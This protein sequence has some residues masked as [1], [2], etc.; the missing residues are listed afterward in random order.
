MLL[1][2]MPDGKKSLSKFSVSF[3]PQK[4]MINSFYIQDLIT[5]SFGLEE[6]LI[7]SLFH[8]FLNLKVIES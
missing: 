5:I 8:S 7:L 3:P 6:S 1:S 4:I 2:S